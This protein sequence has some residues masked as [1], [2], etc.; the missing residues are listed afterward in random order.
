MMKDILE[1]ARSVFPYTSKIR[2]EFHSRPELGFQ[3]FQTAERILRE[4]SQWEGL[5][6]QSG[7]ASTGILATL[8][9]GKP[10]KTVLV[11]FD[12]DALPIQE[13]TGVDFSSQNEGIM[14]ACGHDGHMAVGLTVARL[15]SET[16]QDLSGEVVFLFQ[17][18]EEGLGGALKMIQEGVLDQTRPDYALGI[19]LWNE[20][21]VGWLGISPGPVMSAS[22]TFRILIQGKGGHGGKPHEAVDPITAAAGVINGLQALPSREVHP[23][24]SSVISVCTIHAGTAPNVIPG[25]VA[26]SGTIRTFKQETR[27]LLLQ[28]FREVVSGIASSYG[29]QVEIELDDISPAVQNHP[30]ITAAALRTAQDLFPD[31]IIDQGYQTMASEDM[32]F[33]LEEIPGC[34]LFIG[35]A[36]PEKGLDAKH[37]QPDFNFDEGALRIGVSLLIG[38]ISKLLKPGFQI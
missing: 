11:R 24:D 29:C 32:A 7:I 33:F 30:G 5:S 36:N 16:R 37:H 10:G 3:E 4:L 25:E 18:A 27:E 17:P 14:H 31:A 9:G 12:M 1:R 34:Y 35:S 15:L 20:K 26:L 13:E 38:T 2:R 19:H 8:A 6:I 28:R 21:P 23:L 22:E